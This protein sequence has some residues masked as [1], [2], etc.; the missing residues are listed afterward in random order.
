MVSWWENWVV[1]W[2]TK[3]GAQF[4][5]PSLS[6]IPAL[7]GATFAHAA[8]AVCSTL[9]AWGLAPDD[10]GL[11]VANLV[12]P[13]FPDPAPALEALGLLPPGTP[14]LPPF[15][16]PPPPVQAGDGSPLPPA[17]GLEPLL[18][19]F[20]C[21]ASGR[22]WLLRRRARRTLGDA[23]RFGC[24]ATG[25]PFFSPP[26]ARLILFQVA[27]AVTAALAAGLPPSPIT[28]DDVL[29]GDGC[30]RATVAPAALLRPTLPAS[31]TL[32]AWVTG[33][34]ADATTA[35]VDGSLSTLDYLLRL[36][37][38]A[39]RRWG[40]PRAHPFLPW[41]L[42]DLRE[43]PPPAT[44]T[45]TSWVR[46]LTRTQWR[47]VKGDAQLDAS[48]EAAASPRDAHHV[49][50]PTP[51]GELGFCVALARSL[52]RST[53]TAR[54]RRGWQPGE[55]PASLAR[56][57]AWTADEAVPELY[58]G[59]GR[60]AFESTHPDLPDLALPAWAADAPSFL[61][62]HGAALES[63]AV[64]AALP[65]W[66]DL[67]FGVDLVGPAA[68]AAKNAAPPRPP[69]AG[70]PGVG[71]C[72]LFTGPH[73]H[74]RSGLVQRATGEAQPASPIAPW[75]DGLVASAPGGLAALG[76]LAVLISSGRLSPLA[77]GDEAGWAAAAASLADTEAAKFASA[78]L[79]GQLDVNTDPFFTPA[80]RAA[81]TALLQQADAEAAARAAGAGAGVAAAA[82]LAAAAG[83]R[84]S[85]LTNSP[86]EAWNLAC[87]AL[88]TAL[89]RAFAGAAHTGCSSTDTAGANAAAAALGVLLGRAPWGVLSSDAIPA[90]GRLLAAGS[91]VV[92]AGGGGAH[93]LSPLINPTG[94]D[95]ATTTPP[96]DRA[97]TML[98]ALLSRPCISAALATGGLVPYLGYVHAHALDCLLLAGVKEGG[99]GGVAAAAAA[100]M[101]EVAARL[102]LPATL[103][104]VVR[105]LILALTSG[106]PGHAAAGLAAVG[107]AVGGEATGRHL[108]PPLVSILS[109]RVTSRA[110]TDGGGTCR[111]TTLPSAGA[112]TALEGLIPLLTRAGAAAVVAPRPTPDGRLAP[113]RL[114]GPLLDPAAYAPLAASV[115]VRL[116]NVLVAAADVAA[117]EECGGP[118][119][120]PFVRDLLPQLL[121]LFRALPAARA[122][123]GQDDK[124]SEEPASASPASDVASRLAEAMAVRLVGV[125]G[126]TR[127]G[128]AA[129]QPPSPASEDSGWWRLAATLYVASVAHAPAPALRTLVPGWVSL[130]QGVPRV[131]PGWVSPPLEPPGPADTALAGE[132]GRAADRLA[133]RPGQAQPR[134][135]A[136]VEEAAPAPTPSDEGV[137]AR[138]AAL[139][140]GVGWSHPAVPAAV[141]AE[142]AA[143]SASAPL[144]LPKPEEAS[145]GR[146]GWLPPGL[147][148]PP[149]PDA[150]DGAGWGSPAAWSAGPPRS[151]TALLGLSSKN[152]LASDRGLSPLPWAV[153]ARPL[154]AWRAHRD[155]LRAVA[156]DDDEG[157]VVTA[158]KAG[159]RRGGGGAADAGS[160]PG[161]TQPPGRDSARV[162]TLADGRAGGEY[163][164]HAARIVAL[165]M[166]AGPSPAVAS[167]DEGGA[168]HVWRST[169]PGGGGAW[170]VG[171]PGES[172]QPSVLVVEAGAAPPPPARPLPGFTCVARS[173]DGGLGGTAFVTGTAD[174][175]VGL[176][177][178]GAQAPVA[179]TAPGALW[180]GRAAVSALH[181]PP[182]C[183]WTATGSAAGHVAVVDGRCGPGS[184][185]V[186]AWSAHSGG[187]AVTA[188]LAAPPLLVTAGADRVLRV[189]DLRACGGGDQGSP[190]LLHAWTPLKSVPTGLA[191]APGGGALAHAGPSLVALPPL[192]FPADPFPPSLPSVRAAPPRTAV[193]GLA[194]LPW[195]RLLVLGCD[196]GHVLV[197]K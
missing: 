16:S 116:G 132:V 178:A 148:P 188:L 127:N 66:I 197:C 28:P 40:D 94:D 112:V 170:V 131:L 89:G 53:L 119:A 166:T 81:T 78:C 191:P 77:P 138:A 146:W 75:D 150:G 137:A 30:A 86:A 12:S 17:I 125:V 193:A 62:A 82:G 129:A 44:S 92:A 181:T 15:T 163:T 101:G 118:A 26:A 18:G 85:A 167:L 21:P 121:S 133:G 83:G 186:A 76:R 194:I 155:R 73:P 136:T 27:S 46:D 58:C 63:E 91:A 158:G 173:G 196:D 49:P 32:P 184:A 52:P 55:Y 106:A 139:I 47:L 105:P 8:G 156:V 157:L 4:S 117:G 22:A 135:R 153:Q 160:G 25:A 143:G 39:G 149:T 175:R 164:G 79:M 162:W 1:A 115:R 95:P 51:L 37:V 171:R 187:A 3:N 103:E 120:G 142:R 29:L 134:R 23:L 145:S 104:W 122:A 80:I 93:G 154:H 13:T 183:A 108:V 88:L 70:L 87:P 35:W 179:T 19:A 69:G 48:F 45:S 71:R 11:V 182:G 180:G 10:D 176:A 126:G 6:T 114:A 38:L 34:A 7:P 111:P 24:P 147:A 177:D 72:Q 31:S 109:S 60:A 189:W 59:D 152:A 98:S 99:S 41:V 5:L 174:G 67:T 169:A 50:A 33:G 43:A 185:V 159:P 61:A 165:S 107:K 65:A 96:R 195:S 192:H 110:T 84:S 54:V 102:P 123:F 100:A 151:M 128:P 172:E 141:E 56:L 97:P 161:P 36:Q 124:A 20:T 90:I 14:A 113:A 64:A 42:R 57:A 140:S 168:L 2:R 9:P 190:T 74:R 68:I 130:E 144:A